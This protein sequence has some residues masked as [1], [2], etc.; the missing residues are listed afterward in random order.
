M[1]S[2]KPAAAMQKEGLSLPRGY[3]V[4]KSLNLVNLHPW[5]F[6]NDKVFDLLYPGL[7]E[8]YPARRVVPFAT[9]DD[10]DD[11]ACFV[12]RDIEQELGGIIII[13]DYASPGSEVTARQ[14]TFWEWFKYAV[15]EMIEWHEEV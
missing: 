15:D 9:R 10:N 5:V 12:V 11:V 8:R 4:A 3:E 7:N 14:K 13:H 2:D 1:F 6:A